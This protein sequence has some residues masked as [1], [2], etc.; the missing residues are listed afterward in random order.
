MKDS[1]ERLIEALISKGA[2]KIMLERAREGYYN[3]FQ[4]TIAT[5]IFALIAD[6]EKY[7]LPNIAYRARNGEFDASPEEAQI[8]FQKEGRGLILGEKAN[9]QS[10]TDVPESCT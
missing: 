7:G 5:P 6:A 10:Q 3:D 1:K 8:W 9:E 2:P 4:S